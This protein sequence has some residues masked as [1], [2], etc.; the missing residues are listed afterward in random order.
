MGKL[1]ELS[2][3]IVRKFSIQ[4]GAIKAIFS[5][6][7][8]DNKDFLSSVKGDYESTDQF[9]ED[10]NKRKN[11]VFFIH[12]WNKK[13]TIENLKREF[14]DYTNVIIEKADDICNGILD[15]TG[16]GKID[17]KKF[18]YIPWQYDFIND[19][20]WNPKYY[21]KNI[22]VPYGKGEIK[23]PWEL[24][25]FHYAITLGQAYY[26]TGEEKYAKKFTALFKNWV[27]NNPYPFGVNWKC[28]MEVAIRVSN[29]I[30]GYYF[31]KESP[32]FSKDFLL[33]YL[34][35]I[36]QHSRH[37][38]NNLECTGPVNTNHYLSNLTGLIYAG[39]L[40]PE[41]K[42]SSEW[43][44]FGIKEMF[45]E[46]KKQVDSDGMD[47]EGS[48][49]YHCFVTELLF[50]T[51][52][53][54]KLN[55]ICI[56]DEIN[57]RLDNMFNFVLDTIK[58]NARVP[59]IGD[60]DSGHLHI[61]NVRAPLDFSYLLTFATLFFNKSVFNIKEFNF[62]P[63]AL[64]VFGRQGYDKWQ[65]T[66]T[67]CLSEIKSKYFK[68]SGIY[69][70]RHKK[71]YVIISN[72][73]NGQNGKGGHNHNDKLSFELSVEG[74]D[75]IVDPGTYVYTSDPE[76]RNKFRATK[77]HNTIEVD[78]KEQ[79]VLGD[80]LFRMEGNANTYL[81]EIQES[82]GIIDITLLHD[83][84]RRLDGCVIHS[85]RFIYNKTSR[86][87]KIKDEISGEGE[88]NILFNLH[89][90]DEVNVKKTG[91]QTFT[92]FHHKL[93]SPLRIEVGDFK[94]VNIEEGY[95]SR[96][97]GKRKKAEIISG[98]IKTELPF[99]SE[100]IIHIEDKSDIGDIK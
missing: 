48:T 97:Y 75:I 34:K 47:F 14:L 60:N 35:S 87:L 24:S 30:W 21:Y 76:Y 88:H 29:W 27:D 51:I 20:R 11:P 89:L 4:I 37:I 71:D 67:S 69:V 33:L 26:L 81:K 63:E 18:S 44:N 74:N 43:R 32:S 58:P 98:I 65:S 55:N 19:Y 15:V 78:G 16:A 42:E 36:L 61:I 13:V 72:G 62:A 12:P 22:R 1:K 93:K 50:Y 52:A 5:S 66:E 23:V 38:I 82:H 90:S 85:R 96:E 6:G 45:M 77:Y 3:K 31:F 8:I 41:F 68:Q 84:Y 10:F 94:N 25:R 9:I 70:I 83:G 56:P 79:N 17:L 64:W 59:Q 54:L 57:D 46:I 49:C 40:F 91:T 86:L 28:T 73:S 92:L 7:V 99:E 39:I 53:L 95:I 2:E 100:I 80:N